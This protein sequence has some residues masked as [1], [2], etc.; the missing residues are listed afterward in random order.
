MSVTFIIG[1]GFDLNLGLP[2]SYKDYLKVYRK[3]AMDYPA[4]HILRRFKLEVLSGEDWMWSDFEEGLGHRSILFEGENNDKQAKDFISCF[5]NFCINFTGYLKEVCK[6]VDVP[7]DNETMMHDFIR[8]F[9]MFYKHLSEPE[10]ALKLKQ[11]VSGL[12]L[13]F[14]QF[15]YTD[16]LDRLIEES[17][18]SNKLQGGIKRLGKN[19]HIHGH[20]NDSSPVMGVGRADQIRSDVIQSNPD[21][22]ADFIKTNILNTF[23]EANLP[24]GNHTSSAIDVI[25]NS[26]VICIYGCSI[27]ATDI[28]WWEH[29]GNWLKDDPDNEKELVIFGKRD[30]PMLGILSTQIR[31]IRDRAKK[32][33]EDTIK[34]FLKYA[35]LPS[36]YD[37]YHP[38]KIIIELE[39]DLFDF[40][41]VHSPIIIN[42]KKLIPLDPGPDD[43]LEIVPDDILDAD[44]DATL[45]T[46]NSE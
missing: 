42:F 4:N 1:N 37:T 28:A 27:G 41:L 21:V 31:A 5:E 40:K 22:Q 36:Q 18:L 44:P 32:E 7:Q 12:N 24:P 33:K 25:K 16:I 2:T 26:S 15:N 43:I 3:D 10:A 20:V 30:K 17:D 8:S 38:G 11:K 6:R 34:R 13:N 39:H 14:L 35:G 9:C 29:I 45:E 46:G 23:K 19:L